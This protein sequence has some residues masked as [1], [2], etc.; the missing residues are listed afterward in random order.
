MG[1]RGLCVPR[2][3]A[4]LSAWHIAGARRASSDACVCL[5]CVAAHG[6]SILVV[7]RLIAPFHL[8]ATVV[9]PCGTLVYLPKK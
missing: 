2:Q 9:N 1:L 8:S 3:E 4:K 5:E 6:I 7:V